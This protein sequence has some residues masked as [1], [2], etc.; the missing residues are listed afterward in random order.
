MENAASNPSKDASQIGVSS[1]SNSSDESKKERY[2]PW[3]QLS[4]AE[5]ELTKPPAPLPDNTSASERA[6]L[7]FAVKGNAVCM[8]F[9]YNSISSP[10]LSSFFL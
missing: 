10:C 2:I 7:R 6:A 9:Q 1:N 4:K 5:S 8:Y 3:M